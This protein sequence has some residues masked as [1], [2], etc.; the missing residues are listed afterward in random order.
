MNEM[1][2]G[3]RRIADVLDF[4][5]CARAAPSSRE[6]FERFG[7]PRSSGYELLSALVERDFLRHQ[8]RGHWELGDKFYV[9]A[10]SRFGLGEVASKVDPVLAAL[11]EETQETAQLAVLYEEAIL[12]IHS[13]S[14]TRS[15]RVATGVGTE[16]PVN[17]TAAGRLLVSG[18]DDR[19]LRDFFLA[20][21]RPSPTGRAVTTAALFAREVRDA[22]QRGYAIEI[23]Q[24]QAD[25]CSVAA[26]VLDT[27]GNCLAAV[28]LVLPAARLLGSRDT[29][30]SMVSGAAAKLKIHNASEKG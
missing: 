23:E 29:L 28:S 22:R 17:W 7:L 10:F 18:M 15:M 24:A 3:A 11:Q 8:E 20:H 27:Q 9:L 25:G 6:I 13:L 2:K 30:L 5:A 14:S 21:A 16:I 4:V 12:I 1:S 19:R 26:P